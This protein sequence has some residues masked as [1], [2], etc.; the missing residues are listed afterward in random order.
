MEIPFYQ[1]WY[2]NMMNKDQKIEQ[3]KSTHGQE[4]N[5]KK[6]CHSNRKLQRY[7]QKL[8]KQDL[9]STIDTEPLTTNYVKD[10]SVDCTVISD[11][12]LYERTSVVF[13]QSEKFNQLFNSNPKIRFIRQYISLIDQLSYQKLRETQ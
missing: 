5:R 8:R 10:G 3:V 1:D 11:E 2:P 13:N 12:I 6:R 4:Y 7:R 9:K